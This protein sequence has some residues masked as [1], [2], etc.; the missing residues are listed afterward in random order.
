MSPDLM[1]TMS[2]RW[3]IFRDHHN[4]RYLTSCDMIG[5]VRS[6]WIASAQVAEDVRMEIFPR[7]ALE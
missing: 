6:T 1:Q 4:R 7:T 2:A 5:D 3:K